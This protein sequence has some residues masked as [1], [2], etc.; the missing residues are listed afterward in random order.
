MWQRLSATRPEL[1][2]PFFSL[3]F[4]EAVDA[5]GALAR[6][7][8]LYKG[9]ELAGFFPFQ[10]SNPLAKAFA[11][12]ERIG[13]TLND[14]SGLVIDTSRHGPIEPELLRCA[15]LASFVL[16]II[17]RRASFETGLQVSVGTPRSADQSGF[18][19]PEGV[20]VD[21]Q[22][23]HPVTYKRFSAQERKDGQRIWLNRFPNSP[24]P[25][26][27]QATAAYPGRKA[28]AVRTKTPARRLR[29][30]KARCLEHITQQAAGRCT[31]VVS[32]LYFGGEWA[33][34]HFQSARGLYCI[35][36]SPY[37]TGS[38]KKVSPGLILLARMI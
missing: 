6:V 36:G 32:A 38:L 24:N 2:S 1:R 17:W 23:W 8:L 16:S 14:F 29:R 19:I 15:R 30:A 13:G 27:V 31:P 3:E 20:L 22:Y 26:R 21:N 18:P 12:A 25:S 10:F 7:C 35:H 34:L 4:S 9:G 11:A 37:I 5:S 28:Q 33:A